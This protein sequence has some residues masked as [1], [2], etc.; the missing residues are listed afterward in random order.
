MCFSS[1]L[2]WPLHCQGQV[3]SVSTQLPFLFSFQIRVYVLSIWLQNRLNDYLFVCHCDSLLGNVANVSD[4]DCT[5]EVLSDFSSPWSCNPL[6][7]GRLRIIRWQ[8]SEFYRIRRA[9]LWS[10]QP[11][12][13]QHKCIEAWIINY[14]DHSNN[15]FTTFVN[16]VKP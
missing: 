9:I 10:I 1:L 11:D 15:C 14:S 13:G 8:Y 2:G 12:L 6:C 7:Y 5:P 16:L 3:K 4:I